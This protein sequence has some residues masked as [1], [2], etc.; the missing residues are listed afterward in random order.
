MVFQATPV[1]ATGR[2]PMIPNTTMIFGFATFITSPSTTSTLDD[3]SSSLLYT[4]SSSSQRLFDQSAQHS[5]RIEI[6]HRERAGSLRVSCIVRFNLV[7]RRYGF[8]HRSECEEP[9]THR[10]HRAK[11]G[12]L[13]GHRPASRQI[14]GRTA[15]E[16]AG[17]TQDVAIFGDTPLCLRGLDVL[18]IGVE[19][20]TDL[21]R[22][23]H[24]PSPVR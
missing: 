12:V 3:P 16:P 15:T 23:D 7:D 1:P 4:R 20:G 10:E 21:R 18:A 17:L 5:C 2:H 13:N 14:A 11:A 24:A 22:I 8:L 6:F 19:I 9:L